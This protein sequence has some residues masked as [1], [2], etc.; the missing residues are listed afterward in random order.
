[1]IIGPE[2]LYKLCPAPSL[3]ALTT[4]QC[5]LSSE[6]WTQIYTHSTS[7]QLCTS[8]TSFSALSLWIA[9]DKTSIQ[10]SVASESGCRSTC[11]ASSLV[12]I[13]HLPSY[14]ATFLTLF[15]VILVD[16]SWQDAAGALWTF[17]FTSF[18]LTIS[19]IVQAAQGQLSL[20]QAL[21]VGNLVWYE[22]CWSHSLGVHS[23]PSFGV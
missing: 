20:F 21:T 17:V 5:P 22:C 6:S 14:P 1:V 12:N 3:W 10:T 4:W 16:R 8:T 9:R 11:R 18:A 23:L 7:M 15:P 19:A 2:H 13:I